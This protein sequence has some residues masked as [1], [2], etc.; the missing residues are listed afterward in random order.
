MSGIYRDVTLYATPKTF[1][2][3]HYITS[4]LNESAGYKSGDMKVQLAVSNRSESTSKTIVRASL[5][6][7]SGNLAYEF[8]TQL[9]SDLEA[10]KEQS[11]TLSAGLSNLEL[12]SA[13]TP[14]LYTLEVSLYDRNGNEIEAF[15]TK[16][17]FRHV[18]IK[19]RVVYVNG[20]KVFFK[21]VNR[22]DTHPLHGR[23]VPMESMLTDVTL[24]KRNNINT[25]R[26]S[27]YPNQPKM[28]AMFDYF[29]LY[30]MDEADVECHANTGI[31]N[32]TSWAPAFVDR[33]T[34]MV[35]RDRN[36]PSVVFWSMGNESGCGVNFSNE[37]NAMKALDSRIIHYEGQ[38]TWTY[39]DMTS[40]MYPALSVL[41]SLD[42]SSEAR[43][44]FIC[45]Y[46][47]AMGNAIGNL[48]EYW[49]LIEGSNRIVGGCIWD[50]VDQ[51]IYNPD[52]I[53][54]GA[55]KGLYT[56]S[57]FPGPHQG[58]FCSN[59]ILAPDRNPTSK[60]QEVKKV[61]QYVKIKDFDAKTKSVNIANTYGFWN[62][63]R[64]DIIWTVL[65]NGVAVQTGTVSDFSLAPGAKA[66]M[67]V[68]YNAEWNSGDE[69]ILDIKFALKES[70]PGIEAGHILAREQFIVQERPAME[71][72]DT[73][74]LP[75]TLVVNTSDGVLIEGDGFSYKFD[76]N[77]FLT[78]IVK[79]DVELI[80][81]G[82]GLKY[83]HF[84]YIEND[85]FENTSCY[86]TTTSVTH[87][88]VGDS[89][90]GASAV[91]VNASHSVSGFCTYTVAYTVYADGR[92]DVDASFSP[93]S[94]TGR[95]IGMSMQMAGGYENVEYYGR[96][97]LANHI[98]RKTGAF[99][100]VYETTVDDMHE[101]YV[102]PQ[103]MGNREDVRYICITDGNGAGMKI[104]TDGTVNFSAL[105]YTDIDLKNAAHDF[106]LRRRDETVIHLDCRQRGVGNASCGPGQLSQ[107]DMT[108]GGTY[109][110]KLRITPMSLPGD[111]Y[112][113]PGGEVNPD[114]YL[115]ELSTFGAYED[116][117][118]TA[119]EA[120][121][122]VYNVLRGS[123]VVVQNES[124]VLKAT[125][126]GADASGISSGLWIDMDQDRRFSDSELVRSNADGTWTLFFTDAVPAG[127][128]RARLVVDSRATIAPEDDVERGYVYD[129]K[130]TVKEPKAPVEYSVPGGSMHSGGKTYLKSIAS[131]GAL[132]DISQVYDSAPSSVYQ[133][134]DSEIE[135]S[136]G[137]GF[138]LT[139]Q[140]FEAG[141]ASNTITYQDLRYCRAFIF[142]DWDADGEFEL[143]ETYGVASPGASTTPNNVLCNYNTVM[144]I[145]HNFSVPDNA[146]KG[147]SRI[148]V[149]YQ[150]AWKGVPD[151][152]TQNIFEGMAY[153]IPV[154]VSDPLAGVEDVVGDGKSGVSVYPNPYV[155]TVTVAPAAPGEHKVAIF[156]LQGT[157]LRN[158]TL[159]GVTTF[160]PGL[161][162]GV[163]LMTVTDSEQ[164]TQTVKI[165]SR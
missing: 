124:A 165:I 23:A 110:Y 128:Y 81:G 59:G 7:P 95:R 33:G 122:E 41:S 29:G 44:H 79:N 40:N 146:W 48:Q 89:G 69:I 53:K 72:I 74:T 46:A 116:M 147:A 77:G 38:G 109:S 102:K 94:S 27:H 54:S 4:D 18:E 108:A 123:A 91:V 64:F 143:D 121:A 47:H 15:S 162:P 67:T 151:A 97:P 101:L 164:N 92:M 58:N 45:E 145:S 39:T 22:H 117:D 12:W 112:V 55:I 153:D 129:F 51:A 87:S 136:A 152:N 6:D 107:Y 13:E 25:I 42:A 115:S 26:T 70:V 104:E 10:G 16:Y 119:T 82:N 37:Y 88:L 5:Y 35:L 100:G 127:T 21:G 144:N 139:L 19:D 105:H 14:A 32:I 114:A 20:R 11:V 137:T 150:N 157:M 155:E 36:H 113:V 132:K 66:D 96:G 159:S 131:Y 120:P 63:D 83:D 130:I 142:T 154:R 103:T 158:Y 60:L 3:D 8:P 17:G 118:Y 106:N 57:D 85:K 73:A 1:I 61:Y 78:S 76:S 163:Y 149:I 125:F 148:R 62:L 9:V 93:T 56:G 80:N 71:S 50:W 30:T 134:V 133:L 86:I 90:Q 156:S 138:N 98:D 126:A 161:A 34:R 140:A 84:R 28:Y 65:K 2:R 68:P 43:P 75:A 99:F 160:T 24:M 111:G 31:S 52:E 141:G 135:T 49:D